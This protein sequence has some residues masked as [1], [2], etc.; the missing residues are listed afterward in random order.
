MTG[1]A[2]IPKGSTGHCENTFDFTGISGQSRYSLTLPGQIEG[3]FTLKADP[4]L[5][6]WSPCGGTTAIMNMNTQCYI[7]PTHDEAL[8]AVGVPLSFVSIQ[9]EGSMLTLALFP[10]QVD[11]ISGKITVNV[12]LDWRKCS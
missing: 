12:S 8:I 9:V 5:V 11:R 4:D 2:Q 10:D 6:S 1:F 3:D 7:S